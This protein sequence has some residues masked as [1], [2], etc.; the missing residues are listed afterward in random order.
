[1]TSTKKSFRFLKRIQAKAKNK[2]RALEY[3]KVEIV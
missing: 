3:L 1:M 2:P